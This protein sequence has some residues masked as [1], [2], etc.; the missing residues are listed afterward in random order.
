MA[1]ANKEIPNDPMKLLRW[2]GDYTH[3][4]E[5]YDNNLLR[6]DSIDKITSD[7]TPYIQEYEEY[8]QKLDKV[9]K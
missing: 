2:I 9:E 5:D 7:I 8:E 3:L 6:L 1:T 4:V